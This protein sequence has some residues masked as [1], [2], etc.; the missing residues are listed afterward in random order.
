MKSVRFLHLPLAALLFTF[1]LHAWGAGV[2]IITHGLE[3]QSGN[4]TWVVDMAQAI[5]A[6]TGPATAI[7]KMQVGIQSN[8]SLGVTSFTLQSGN[9]PTPTSTNAEVV[10]ELFWDTV[11]GPFDSQNATDI[12]NQ[13]VPYLLF[14]LNWGGQ[15]ITRPFAELPVHVIGHSRGGSV[16]AEISR[17]LA[18]QGVWVDD[19]T[20]L[21]PHPLTS[22][23]P[24]TVARDPAVLIYDNVVFADNYYEVESYPSGEH[25]DGTSETYLNS[26]FGSDGLSD[27]G[28]EDHT[29]VHD[30]Y[31]GTIDTN[32]TTVDGRPIPRNAWYVPSDQGFQYSLVGGGTYNGGTRASNTNGLRITGAIRTFVTRTATGS[33]LWDNIAFAGW[34][35]NAIIVQG[36]Q[37]VVNAFYDD[38]NRDA[39]VRIGLDA[40]ATPYDGITAPLYSAQTSSLTGTNIQLAFDTS[41]V[42]AGTYFLCAGISNAVHARW[43]VSRGRITVLQHV[44]ALL[45]LARGIGN[46]VTLNLSGQVGGTY[47]IQV[48]SNLVN[49][50]P[51]ATN[52]LT[53]QVWQFS[54]T[55]QPGT[56][57]RFY[58]GVLV[59]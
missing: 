27:S 47:V 3:I 8:G 19:V 59:N 34:A 29:E 43:S 51:L 18:A 22:A 56:V 33:N 53:N 7:L 5:A 26:R 58:R 39:T 55:P 38:V 4:P 30:W 40:D 25:I 36:E 41:G 23:D 2:T 15:T 37:L 46:G 11:A 32:A 28:D 9:L 50:L 21:D 14:S 42:P 35:T 57:R 49:W 45:Q 44:G 24:L 6:R 48:S 1:C 17:L 20:T 52:V 16:V 13:V 31:H 10:I 54:D 12:A